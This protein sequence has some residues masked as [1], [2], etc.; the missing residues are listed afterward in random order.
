MKPYFNFTPFH[1]LQPGGSISSA[2]EVPGK[3]F[4]N[5]IEMV[6]AVTNKS[7]LLL[8][9]SINGDCRLQVDRSV[10]DEWLANGGCY[11]PL[12][13]LWTYCSNQLGNHLY[14]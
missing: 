9:P 5:H 6:G 3:L 8:S 10:S 2:L 7:L 13:I 1:C 12:Y 4:V 14:L 11:I